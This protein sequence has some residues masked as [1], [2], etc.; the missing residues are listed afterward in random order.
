MFGRFG[1]MRLLVRVMAGGAA[2]RAIA[3]QETLRLAKPVCGTID[4]PELIV[5]SGAGR[6]IED[7]QEV[8]ERLAGDKGIRRAI[9]SADARGDLAAGWL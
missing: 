8:G 1:A 3:L 9:E 2:H 7:Q 5:M 4:N 6:V